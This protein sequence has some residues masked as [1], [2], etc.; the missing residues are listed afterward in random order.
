MYRRKKVV[1]TLLWD[2][3]E[4]KRFVAFGRESISIEGDQGVFGPMLLERV[5][6]SEK[7]R[8]V[9]RVCDKCSPYFDGSVS[10]ADKKERSMSYLSAS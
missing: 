4:I 6:E 3:S 10:A 7:T 2:L 5:V 9:L 8:E 1:D